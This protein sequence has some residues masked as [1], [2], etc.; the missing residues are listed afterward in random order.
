[1]ARI[2]DTKNRIF[3]ALAPS[4]I[5]GLRGEPSSRPRRRGRPLPP[6]QLH[7]PERWSWS[8]SWSCCCCCCCCR[9]RRRRCPWSAALPRAAAPP[10]QSWRGPAPARAGSPCPCSGAEGSQS[11][12]S[13]QSSA[14]RAR[15]WSAC[16]RT[17]CPAGQ[18]GRESPHAAH[19]LAGPEPANAQVLEV[20]G[21]G[22]PRL[23]VVHPV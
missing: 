18:G 12:S 10:G 7:Q 1:M 8:W 5:H 23:A 21:D 11:S 13:A 6:H 15:C 22:G 9:R 16:L 19:L 17:T 3:Y 2:L 14:P 20:L 4:R